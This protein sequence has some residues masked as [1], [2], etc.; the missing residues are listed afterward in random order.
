MSPGRL[1]LVSLGL[2]L[3]GGATLGV[4]AGR[5]SAQALVAAIAA[6]ATAVL[7]LVLAAYAERQLGPTQAVG[8]PAAILF[9]EGLGAGVAFLIAFLI[10]WDFP[11]G[12]SLT[13]D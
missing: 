12:L 7:L 13:V 10:A 4:A 8:F 9:V 2:A 11:I 6:L 5:D 3:T 1:Y